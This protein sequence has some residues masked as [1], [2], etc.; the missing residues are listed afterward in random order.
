MNAEE[1][2]SFEII[3]EVA[4]DSKFKGLEDK[5][6]ATEKKY[7]ELNRDLEKKVIERT[8]EIRK[9]LKHNIK[10]IDSLSHDLATPLTPLISLLPML[11]EDV[12]DPKKKELL[13]TCLRNVEYIKRVINNTRELADISA[14]N[15]MLKDE[16]LKEIIDELIEKYNATFKNFNITV[17]NN[18]AE[19]ILVKSDKN[20]LLQL[21]D[22][23][24][25]NAVN[26]MSEGG[27]LSINSKNVKKDGDAFIQISVKDTGT[28]LSSD[29]CNHIFE[30]FYKT[31]DARHKLDSTGL[32]LAICKKIIEKHDG[33]I[34]ADSHGKDT[35]TAIHFTIPS[36]TSVFDRSF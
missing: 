25:S 27:T 24:F 22:H 1:E 5:L 2:T 20:R 10:F 26:S 36:N 15:L 23:I 35:G 13:D 29:Q 31:D 18:I 16:K 30:E 17:E 21:L 3:E 8:I 9:L 4:Q 12:K 19:D 32:G 28:G 11:K 33:K 34:W 7:N 14:S 6:K